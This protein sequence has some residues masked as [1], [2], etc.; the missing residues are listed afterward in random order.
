MILD[1]LAQQDQAEI[2]VQQDQPV[3]LVQRVPL[4]RLAKLDQPELRVTQV[5]LELL[6]QLVLLVRQEQRALL[7][8]SVQ[9]ELLEQ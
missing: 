2:S 8:K 6:A 7:A 1:R 3:L 4:V 5:R 9:P